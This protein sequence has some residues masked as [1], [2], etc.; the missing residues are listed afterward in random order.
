MMLTRYIK[1]AN[2]YRS[3]I[4][5]EEEFIEKVNEI[6]KKEAKVEITSKLDTGS[7]SKATFYYNFLNYSILAGCVYTICIIIASFREEK[8][9]K[10]TIISSMNYKKHNRQLIISNGI[11][12]I[13]LWFAYVLISFVM[14]GDIMFTE[15]GLIL[16]VNSFIFSIC[17]L[18]IAFLLANLIKNKG[19]ISGI[20]NVVALRFKFF[21]WFFCISRMVARYS[22]KN[23]TF[24]T[25][26]L[27]Y[28]N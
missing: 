12:T 15:H 11:L 26:V 10:R 4:K 17:C 16:I 21:M 20:I 14:V 23:S 7:L 19:A 28:T 6:L 27:V 9:K 2:I 5:N 18:T 22:S 25:F 1:V 13:V 8:I 3:E 24:S